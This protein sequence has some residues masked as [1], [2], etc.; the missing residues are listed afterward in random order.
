MTGIANPSRLRIDDPHAVRE[1]LPRA[2]AGWQL[3]TGT[4]GPVMT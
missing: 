2:C 4:V 1:I 3:L